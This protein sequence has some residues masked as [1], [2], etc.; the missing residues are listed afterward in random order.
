[1]AAGLRRAQMGCPQSKQKPQQT[2]EWRDAK[3]R[4]LSEMGVGCLKVRCP[5]GDGQRVDDEFKAKAGRRWMSKIGNFGALSSLDRQ[6]QPG[7]VQW[8]SDNGSLAPT[9]LQWSLDGPCSIAKSQPSVRAA[10]RLPSTCHAI[11]RVGVGAFLCQ[12][13]WLDTG[14]L[15]LDSKQAVHDTHGTLRLCAVTKNGDVEECSSSLSQ[16]QGKE[17]IREKLW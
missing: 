16:C 11:L 12:E 17:Y 14:P 7:R 3:A 5:K 1:M 15:P 13:V 8:P 4:G 10:S 2:V 6:A 9:R